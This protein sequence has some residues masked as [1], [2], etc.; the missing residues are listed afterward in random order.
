MRRTPVVP[1]RP[2]RRGASPRRA[3]RSGLVA[4]VA[5]GLVGIAVPSGA[6]AA[7]GTP[8]PE[9]GADQARPVGPPG[10]A[11]AVPDGTGQ[12]APKGATGLSPMTSSRTAAGTMTATATAAA[13]T[14]GWVLHGAGWGHGIGMSQYGA[15]E[16]AKDGYK[17]AQILN[18]YYTGTTYDAVTDTQL[19]DVNVLYHIDPSSTLSASTTALA[20]G[21]G[22]FTVTMAGASG[23]M[24]GTTTTPLSFSMVSGKIRATCGSCTGATTLTGSAATLEWDKLANDKTLLKIGGTQ[25][26]DGTIRITPYGTSSWNVVNRVRLHDEY[27]DYIA[28][29]PWSWNVEALKAQAA[30]ARGYA[31]A[32]YT[33]L[34]GKDQASCA[35]HLLDTTS[36]QVYGGYTT[37]NSN[38][39]A[40]YWQNWKNAVRASGSGSTGYVA[41]SSGT[42]IQAFF[43]SSSGGRTENN[44]D[45]WGGTPLPYLRG[46]SDPWSLRPSNPLRAWTQ[47]TNGSSMASAF[48]LPDV[49]RLDLRDRT[50][51]GGVHTAVA[52]SSTGQT[53]TITGDRMRGI[54]ASGSAYSSALNSTMIRHLTGRLA[55]SDRYASATAVASRVPL[56]ANAVVIAGGDTTL[57]DAS[58]S[59]PLATTVGGPLLLTQQG[60]LPAATVAELNRRG[61]AVKTAY[62]VGGTGV[63]S[64]AVE[65]QLRGR[66]LAVTRL[67]GRDRYETSALVA[68]AIRAKRSTPTVVV[69]GG[70]GLVDALGAS[71]PASALKEPILLTQASTLTPSTSAALTAIGATQSRIVGGPA[72]VSSTV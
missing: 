20:T 64:S 41:R 61:S 45:V 14:P 5:V 19:L 63:V 33:R 59:G 47:T 13:S 26:R 1:P 55:G 52:T 35:C 25:Y 10:E 6:L 69:A 40:P 68:K 16:M 72:V 54:A 15:Y 67:G 48:G 32:K 58:V 27:L 28:E 22:A 2:R 24:S 49:Q 53:S 66:G 9:W 51:N 21:G 4:A 39:N 62:I 17:A 8:G 65:S 34:G 29:S 44:E 56:S 12:A 46:V 38:G 71:G 23:T 7:S 60:Q 31:L 30:A 70:D 3:L 57:S 42:I 43:S 11:S 50:V 37:V 36:D 18:H